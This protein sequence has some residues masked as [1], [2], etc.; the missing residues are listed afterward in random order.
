[1]IHDCNSVGQI[2][3]GVGGNDFISLING[4]ISKFVNEPFIEPLI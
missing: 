2:A 3:F 4:L 1:M